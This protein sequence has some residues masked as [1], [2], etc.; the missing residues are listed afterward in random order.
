MSTCVQSHKVKIKHSGFAA[1][2]VRLSGFDGKF[3]GI[4]EKNSDS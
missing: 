2:R 1:A 4:V 3:P